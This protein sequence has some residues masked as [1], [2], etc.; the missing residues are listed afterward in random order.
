MVVFRL[1]I[2]LILLF[3]PVVAVSQDQNTGVTKLVS[4]ELVYD[5]ATEQVTLPHILQDAQ[6]S[7]TTGR[8]FYVLRFER[9]A[10]VTESLAIYIPKMSLSGRVFLNGHDLGGCATGPLESVRCL[11]RPILLSPPP[12]TWV[13][14]DN[15][16]ELEVFANKRQMNGLSAIYVGPA[17]TLFWTRY[18]PRRFIQIDLVSGLGWVSLTLA[19]LSLATFSMLSAERLYLWFSIACLANALSNLNIVSS[20]PLWA[21]EYFSWLIFSSRYMSIA[22][23]WLTLA[24][25]IKVGYS[26]LS[27]LL[28]GIA[29]TASV[30]IWFGD[31]NRWV[32][33]VAY[34]P[35]GVISLLLTVIIVREAFRRRGIAAIITAAVCLLIMVSSITDWFRL[36]GRAAFDGIYLNIY[37]IAVA[38]L[39]IG[40]LQLSSLAV[41]LKKSRKLA[42]GLDAE[43]SARTMELEQL[44]QQLM[45]LSRTD[46]LTGLA[47]RRWF[48][49]TLSREFARA[50]RSRSTLTVMI[51]DVDYFKNYND[52]YGHPAGDVCLVEVT[53]WLRQQS[54]RETDFLARI[55]GEE[56]ALIETVGTG[57]ATRMMAEKLCESIKQA[58]LPHARSPLG[59]VT[60]SIGI[61]TYNTELD[62]TAGD[63]LSRADKALYRA[64]ANGR[65][66]VEFADEQSL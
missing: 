18:L 2:G 17:E 8:V 51:I 35:L 43:V 1:L 15:T 39:V 45:V 65:N 24:K 66:R 12:S 10:D 53:A 44:N 46:S 64:K 31:N 22:F 56:F 49:E 5:S 47:N 7:N 27:P 19:V 4:A 37:S 25:A 26:W 57:D 48:D 41:A 52:H 21:T 63:L 20:I 3:S 9:P 16:L 59:Y 60:I 30:S 38:M 23:I 34:L 28:V 29:I 36:A 40:S 14:G 33:V 55:G 42:E 11:N 13:E 58:Q 50:Q 6:I 32:T 61:A 54:R 62:Q